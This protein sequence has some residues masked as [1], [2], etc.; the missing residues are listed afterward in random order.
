MAFPLRWKCRKAQVERFWLYSTVSS[1]DCIAKQS[2]LTESQPKISLVVRPEECGQ[3]EE[4][5]CICC[6]SD[7]PTTMQKEVK[8]IA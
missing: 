7:G 1:N 8:I 2:I 4:V 6:S 5:Y 3:E